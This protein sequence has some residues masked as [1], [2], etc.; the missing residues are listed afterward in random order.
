MNSAAYYNA[1]FGERAERCRD[2]RTDRGK[3]NRGIEF[4][5]RHFVGTASPNR[6]K[7]FRGLLCCFVARAS[8]RE[9]FA[10]FVNRNLRDQMRR[11]AKTVNAKAPR[12][13]GFAIRS[14][15]DQSRAKQR[16]NL[17]II[18]TLRQM[19][20]VSRIGHGELGVTASIV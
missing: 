7:F 20:T 4:F 19:E 3:D 1:A 6:A 5:R 10:P 15:T 17:D 12:I 11:V 18:V 14:V 16:C 9:E 13:A 8:E 2:E